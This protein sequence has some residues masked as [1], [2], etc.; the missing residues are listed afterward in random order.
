M[1]QPNIILYGAQRC[2]KTKYYQSYLDNLQLKYSF[3]D[4]EEN[5]A[6]AEELRSLYNNRK[7]NFPTITIGNKKLR[8]PSD[9]DL[10]KWL[11]KQE[12]V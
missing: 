12:L 7:L 4:V 1:S 8:N 11:K 6:F 2:H 10:M 3:L 5:E 9:N